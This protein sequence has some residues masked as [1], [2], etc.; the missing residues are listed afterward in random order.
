MSVDSGLF[1]VPCPSH[2]TTFLLLGLKEL[3]LL[4][5]T[6]GN[7]PG[8]FHNM[9]LRA[10]AKKLQTKGDSESHSVGKVFWK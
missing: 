9:A 2:P 5:P 1:I 3:T 7:S 10:Q 4:S 8:L 6:A